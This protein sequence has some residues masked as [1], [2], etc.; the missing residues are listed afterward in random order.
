MHIIDRNG[1]SK[2]KQKFPT[3][4]RWDDGIKTEVVVVVVVIF[5]VYSPLRSQFLQML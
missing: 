1:E 3:P 2:L 5:R 4:A